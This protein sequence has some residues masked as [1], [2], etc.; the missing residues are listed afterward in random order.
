MVYQPI[1]SRVASLALGYGCHGTKEITLIDL[2]KS[3]RKQK[4]NKAQQSANPA[5]KSRVALYVTT[6]GFEEERQTMD[7]EFS[8]LLLTSCISVTLWRL[9][10]ST[11]DWTVQLL[12]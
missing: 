9:K 4:H 10:S 5:H 3:D 8:R 1:S 12:V 6:G 7:G 11:T 2:C